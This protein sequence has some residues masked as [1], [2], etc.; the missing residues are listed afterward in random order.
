MKDDLYLELLEDLASKYECYITYDS[1]NIFLEKI[2]PI[3]EYES[4]KFISKE[5]E[6]VFMNFVNKC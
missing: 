2:I 6:K 1:D 3:N 4:V 5:Y